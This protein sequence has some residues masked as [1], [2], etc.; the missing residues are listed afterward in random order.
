VKQ[1][2]TVL[3]AGAKTPDLTGRNILIRAS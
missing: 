2:Q 1:G 3:V